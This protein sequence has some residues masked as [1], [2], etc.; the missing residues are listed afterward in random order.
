MATPAHTLA[1]SWKGIRDG[2]QLGAKAVVTP[3]GRFR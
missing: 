3:A 2:G 1:G